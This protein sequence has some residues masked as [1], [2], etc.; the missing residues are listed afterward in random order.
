MLYCPCLITIEQ[1]IEQ[2]TN[3]IWIRTCQECGHEQVGT[4]PKDT[5][6]LTDA[7]CEAKCKQ[8]KSRG[9]LDL[10]SYQ[11]STPQEIEQQRKFL[12]SYE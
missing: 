7:Y 3:M 4:E 5:S 12:E 10:G 6:N 2:Q 11:P 1:Q 9:S 8:C